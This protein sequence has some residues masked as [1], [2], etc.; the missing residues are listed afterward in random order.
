MGYFNFPQSLPPLYKINPFTIHGKWYNDKKGDSGAVL[1]S[2]HSRKDEL[3]H[4]YIQQ[5]G[6]GQDTAYYYIQ[7]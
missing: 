2:F 7:R 5:I 3:P 4:A 1:E 6:A